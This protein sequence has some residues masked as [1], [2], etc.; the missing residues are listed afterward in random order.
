MELQCSLQ[1]EL[2]ISAYRIKTE[3]EALK[4]HSPHLYPQMGSKKQP[5]GI[6]GFCT[7]NPVVR[8]TQQ[9]HK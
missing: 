9:Q 1:S 6:L 4:H 2:Y 5:R 3:A 7:K 8:N